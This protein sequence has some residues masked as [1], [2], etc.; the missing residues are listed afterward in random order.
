[1]KQ[2]A[3]YLDLGALLPI[4]SSISKK[5]NSARLILNRA[6]EYISEL[7][8]EIEKLTLRKNDMLASVKH[9]Q[10]AAAITCNFIDIR[11]QFWYMKSNKASSSYEYSA[12]DTKMVLSQTCCRM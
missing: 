6:V 9:K 2:H 3:T 4:D 7:E 5:R 1:M 10:S 11:R 8:Q 12:E